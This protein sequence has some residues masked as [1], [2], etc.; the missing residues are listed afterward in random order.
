MK[1]YVCYEE[2]N[3]DIAIDCGAINALIVFDTA[4]KAKRWF[5][6]RANNGVDDGFV[7]D[8]DNDIFEGLAFDEERL[9]KAIEGGWAS[10]TM[11]RGYQEN[12]DESFE[13]CVYGQEV[14]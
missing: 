4:E 12:W 2:N 5:T 7:I 6:V 13:I 9:L 1:V 3:H 14:Q 10:I 8:A 11:F